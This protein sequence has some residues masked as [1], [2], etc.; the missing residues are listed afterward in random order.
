[1]KQF[2]FLIAAVIFLASC[3]TPSPTPTTAPTAAP[4]PSV[5]PSPRAAD[6][7][8]PPAAAIP[9]TA[10]ST[11]IPL[12]I[13]DSKDVND[14]IQILYTSDPEIAVYY[15]PQS[16]SYAQFP[17]ALEKLA[18]IREYGASVAPYIAH[19]ISYPRAD[20]YLA[21]KV[22]ITLA[23]DVTASTLPVLIG[24][25]Q[26][27]APKTRFNS[28]IVLGSIGK[29]ASCSVGDIGPLLWDSDSHVRLASAYALE[30]II[31]KSFLPEDVQLLPGPLSASTPTDSPEGKMVGIARSW[32]TDEGSKI[33]WHPSYDLC[34][35]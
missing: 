27:S 6:T 18:A 30:K 1:M 16:D 3:S 23:P 26:K 22:L 31:G 20:S 4:R 33:K 29:M 12:K 24:N 7:T 11:L 35:P 21:A 17:A 28:L 10:T 5:T 9:S 8:L 14:L 32:W 25:L 15:D 2:I 34:D 13:Y 19:A